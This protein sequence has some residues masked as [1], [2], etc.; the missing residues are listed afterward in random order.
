MAVVLCTT[1]CPN[2]QDQVA[3]NATQA[4]PQDQASDPAAANLAPVAGDSSAPAPA[5]YPPQ[6]AAAQ[7]DTSGSYNQ[8]PNQGYDQGSD[9]PG[10]GVQPV[11]YA[12]Q[13]PPPLPDYD[14]PPAPGDD[15]LWTP[16]YWAWAPLG[17]TGFP[18]A[19]LRLPTRARFGRPATG[20]SGITATD[21]TAATG[22]RTSATM[23]ASITASVMSAWA[24]RAVIG[25]AGTSITT[26]QSTM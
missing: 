6:Q 20:A 1:G 10:Y 7:P 18:A 24:T 8:A 15:Y 5:A 22:G 23:A 17:I 9:D 16:G 19:G 25:G 2:S 26:A 14:Q 3:A 11:S 12:P 4:A 13:P 21:S